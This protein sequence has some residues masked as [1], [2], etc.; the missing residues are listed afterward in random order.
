MAAI[1]ADP[2]ILEEHLVV[3][4]TIEASRNDAA[5]QLAGLNDSIW[6][7]LEATI[8]SFDEDYKVFSQRA[9]A[10]LNSRARRLVPGAA[11]ATD[12]Y[13]EGTHDV[14]ASPYSMSKEPIIIDISNDEEYLVLLAHYNDLCFVS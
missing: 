2:Q 11:Q 10:Y 4:A 3:K 5:T 12:H 9:R 7:F 6:H 13:E 1:C 14:E 8:G